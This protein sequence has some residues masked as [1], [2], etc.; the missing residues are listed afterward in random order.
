[1]NVHWLAIALLLPVL[2]GAGAGGQVGNITVAEAWSRGVPGAAVGVVYLAIKNQDSAPD[3]LLALHTPAA[4]R[5]EIH[6]TERVAGM[7]QMRQLA[8]LECPAHSTVKIEPGGVHIM[9]LEL[10]RPLTSGSDFPLTLRFEKAGE[11][12]IQV[13][14]VGQD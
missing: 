5:A 6:R 12:T 7:V 13:Q 1:M 4:R 14:V 10:A 8:S 11:I 9:L 3:R 2:L